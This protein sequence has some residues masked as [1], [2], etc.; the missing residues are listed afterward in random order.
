[1]ACSNAIAFSEA[2][3]HEFVGLAAAVEGEEYIQTLVKTIDAIKA[4]DGWGDLAALA[5]EAG[6]PDVTMET[7]QGVAF[8]IRSAAEQFA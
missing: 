7:V 4:N 3:L 8:A 2:E 1:M 5:R 6:Y